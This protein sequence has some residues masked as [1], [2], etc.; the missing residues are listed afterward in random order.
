MEQ[1][2]QKRILIGISGGIAAY[3]ICTL[4]SSLTKKGHD[5]HVILTKEAKE[6]VSPLTLQTLSHNKVLDEVLESSD[7]YGVEHIEVCN[8]ADV[9]VVAPAT[10]N[11]MAKLANGIADDMLTTTF[12]ASTCKK[13]V[14]PAMNCHMYDNPATKR[15]MEILR[16]Y[17]VEVIEPDSG[18]LACGDTGKGRLMEPSVIEEIIIGSLVEDRFMVGKNVL[19]TSG[20]TREAIDP[21]RYITNHSTGKMGASL[22]RQ[23]RNLGANVTLVSG[24]EPAVEI[25]GVNVE[26]VI[27]AED[28]KN[29]VLAHQEEMDVFILAAAVADFTPNI[30]ADEKIHKKDGDLSLPLKRTTDIL[31]TLGE[32]RRDNQVLIG[33][34]MET[35]NLLENTRRKL[36]TKK[37]D[38][39]VANSLRE[40]GAGFGTDTNI[41]TIISKD[42]EVHLGLQSKDE[43]AY[44][45]L[46]HVFKKG[47]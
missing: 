18:Y 26:S 10:A 11:T 34:S 25:Y 27:S 43:T 44:E 42:S 1:M 15:N 40:K 39:I 22:A 2:Q 9:F 28:M 23:A 29:A 38:Y 12:L 5:V 32:T 47:L 31:K 24:V 30:V 8:K 14:F 7:T 13:L 19:I 35:E 41:V 4:V 46:E 16:S 17:G 45:I 6:L 21:V 37:C 33:F 3:K 36:K 20:P